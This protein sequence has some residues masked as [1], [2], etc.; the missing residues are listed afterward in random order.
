VAQSLASIDFEDYDPALA[1]G[2]PA[3]G[4]GLVT[5]P[6]VRNEVFDADAVDAADGCVSTLPAANARVIAVVAGQLRVDAGAGGVT[7][8]PGEFCLVPASAGETRLEASRETRFLLVEP[9]PTY[10]PSRASARPAGA[11]GGGG[12]VSPYDPGPQKGISSSVIGSIGGSSGPPP[13]G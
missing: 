9:G 13:P 12:K 1:G 3:P 10:P 7:L 11:F 4:N 2:T 6:Q 8:A 5:R